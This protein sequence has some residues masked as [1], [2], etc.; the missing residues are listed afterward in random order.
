MQNAQPLKDFIAAVT[1][2]IEAG[3][4]ESELPG[5]VAEH[6]KKLIRSRDWLPPEY[7]HASGPSYSQYLLYCD[8]LERFS[9][10]SFVWGPKQQTPIHNHT[11]WGVI[12]QLQ[13]SEMSQS[14]LPQ[15]SGAPQPVGVPELMKAGGIA[16][17]APPDH[18][19]HRV[20]NPSDTETAISIHVYG[21]NIGRLPRTVFDPA[22]GER[23]VFI[24]S[25]SNAALPNIWM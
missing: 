20:S 25:Y 23:S 9:V 16:H 7:A 1:R 19:V 22:T 24:S 4:P 13:G 21:A 15:E 14:F 6:M 18:D 5:E 17:V 3:T 8:P 2:L 10:V 12:G 11:V